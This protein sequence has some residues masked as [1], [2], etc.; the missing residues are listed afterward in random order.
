MVSSQPERLKAIKLLNHNPGLPCWLIMGSRVLTLF[1]PLAVS[2][3]FVLL[4]WLGSHSCYKHSESI[5]FENTLVLLRF[6]PFSEETLN[7]L[8]ILLFIHFIYWLLEDPHWSAN[9]TSILLQCSPGRR[10][11]FKS[12]LRLSK[13]SS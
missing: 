5:H 12:T 1:S 6:G 3:L 10:A 13:R 11:F 9:S 4:F 7:R 2:S 8:F